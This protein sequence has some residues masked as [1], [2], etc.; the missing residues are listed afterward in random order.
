MPD[1]SVKF[2]LKA[3]VVDYNKAINKAEKQHVKSVRGMQKA[4]TNS[5]RVMVRG[6]SQLAG[7]FRGVGQEVSALRPLVAAVATIIAGN[8]V[9]RYADAWLNTQNQLR[10]VTESTED[11][12]Q[13]TE[14]LFLISQQSRAGFESTSKLYTRMALATKELGVSQ[15]DLLTVT[16]AINQS[17]ALSGSTVEETENAIIQLSQ[18]LAAGALRGDEFN[19]VSEQAPGIMDALTAATGKTRGEL[20]EMAADGQIT[21]EL[22]LDSMKRAADGIDE[23]FG[24][25]FA[26]FNQQLTQASNNITKFVGESEQLNTLVTDAG[27]VIVTLSENVGTLAAAVSA[28]AVIFAGRY[29]EGLRVASVAAY[30]KAKAN[31]ALVTSELEM[32]KQAQQRAV[33]EQAAAARSLKMARNTQLRSQAI[34][35]L[36]AANQR[37]IATETALTTATTRYAAAATAAGIATRGLSAAMALVGGPAGL[38]LLAAYGIYQ[39][40]TASDDAAESA[41]NAQQHIDEM[42]KG[43]ANVDMSILRDEIERT[44]TAIEEL[45]KVEDGGLFNGDYDRAQDE[46]KALNRQLKILEKAYGDAEAAQKKAFDEKQNEIRIQ[47]EKEFS[48]TLTKLRRNQTKVLRDELSKQKSLLSQQ[49]NDLESFQKDL[50]GILDEFDEARN[51][52]SGDQGKD[53]LDVA[54]LGQKARQELNTGDAEKAL[55]L[56]QQARDAALEAFEAGNITRFNADNQIQLARQVAEQAGAKISEEKEK[57]IASL[58]DFVTQLSDKLQ[59]INN[60]ELAYD[61]ELAKQNTDQILK[62]L[63]RKIDTTPLKAIITPV[64]EAY[65]GTGGSAPAVSQTQNQKPPPK[66]GTVE[67][68]I[69]GKKAT[70]TGTPDEIKTLT[71]EA[72]RVSS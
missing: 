58:Q 41:A 22:I 31:R 60:V 43:Y 46:I 59:K 33:Q 54:I 42:A 52:L 16:K 65:A 48:K 5:Q 32:A 24:E 47:S 14:E 39:Y 11:L 55:E 35:R 45:K 57:E 25:S 70:L 63:Q 37:L 7:S 4:T 40:A 21:A 34:T 28:I 12:K 18:G 66:I 6:N 9:T 49:V 61:E 17:F 38:A 69:G 29:L 13:T 51:S 8:Q 64:M 56:A 50:D 36:A 30:N 10:Q 27:A 23:S 19:S 20:R 3:D 72:K 26:T 62:A 2:V 1:P 53:Y 71:R 68:N 44:K 15:S 67:F